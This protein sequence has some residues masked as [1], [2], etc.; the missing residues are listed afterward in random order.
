MKIIG[1]KDTTSYTKDF[2]KICLKH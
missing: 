2:K 1:M